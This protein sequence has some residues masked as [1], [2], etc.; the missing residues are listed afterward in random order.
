MKPQDRAEKYEWLSA[1]TSEDGSGCR[2]WPW[3]VSA[4]GYGRIYWS[5]GAK[6]VGHVVLELTGRPRPS[7]A[8]HQLHSCD[9]PS[10]AAPWHLRWGT[11]AENRQESIERGRHR[12]KLTAEQ[13]LEIYTAWGKQRD[14]AA[15][16][17]VSQRAVWGIKNGHTWTRVTGAAA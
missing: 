6:L 4:K 14:I 8:H 5:G 13:V 7:R 16:Y 15:R 10:C 12:T 11:N 9:R 2:D 1:V 3:A 17:G